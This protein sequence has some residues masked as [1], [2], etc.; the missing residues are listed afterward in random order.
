LEEGGSDPGLTETPS[1]DLKMP[2]SCVGEDLGKDLA[3][4]P[5]QSLGKALPKSLL[6]GLDE[7]LTRLLPRE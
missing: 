6:G 3:W 7:G 2:L 1:R 5:T 4:A